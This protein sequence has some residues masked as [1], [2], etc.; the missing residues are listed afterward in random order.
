MSDN[1]RAKIEALLDNLTRT[2]LML[3]K[4]CGILPIPILLPGSIQEAEEVGMDILPAV[5]RAVE[6]IED[7][8]LAPDIA[9]EVESG[10]LFWI[11]ALKVLR[12]LAQHGDDPTAETEITLLLIAAGGAL[13]DAAS[14]ILGETD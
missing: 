8:P 7:Q 4:V 3:R 6:I 12:H 11:S 1:P 14:M 9:R 10:A 5:A 2:Y 13:I